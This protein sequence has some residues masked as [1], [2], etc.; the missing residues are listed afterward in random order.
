MT[1]K[2]CGYGCKSLG[3]Y[4]L[5]ICPSVLKEQMELK[6]AYPTPSPSN[7][8]FLCSVPP[9][10]P[11]PEQDSTAKQ[12]Q[13]CLLPLWLSPIF[14]HNQGRWNQRGHIPFCLPA[15]APLSRP[16]LLS[17]VLP[18]LGSPPWWIWLFMKCLLSSWA[19]DLSVSAS[20]SSRGLSGW[21]WL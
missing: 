15:K 19:S 11:L 12:Q 10:L 6:G 14:T 3:T 1:G 21:S 8:G 2:I 16:H 5:G 17:S 13:H 4:S 7:S 20:F 9:S 18:Q